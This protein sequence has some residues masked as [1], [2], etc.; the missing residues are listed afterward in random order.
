MDRY[1]IKH[2]GS[3]LRKSQPLL[4][5]GAT[6][7]GYTDNIL[8]AGVFTPQEVQDTIPSV[9]EN[10]QAILIIHP[11]KH[12]ERLHRAIKTM[13]ENLIDLSEEGGE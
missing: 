5:L 1:H 8:L 10:Y 12:N 6:M 11:K 7:Q 4:G 2:N 9:F 13:Q 3:Y